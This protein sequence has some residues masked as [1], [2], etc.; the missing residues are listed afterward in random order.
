[1]ADRCRLAVLIA[2]WLCGFAA[3]FAA[4][5]RTS[6]SP[7]Q[8]RLSRRP[9]APAPATPTPTRSTRPTTHPNESKFLIHLAEDQKDIWTSPFHLKPGDA[10]WL[11]PAA[12]IT[13]GLLV[14]DPQSSYAMRLGDLSAWKTASNVGV[15]SAMGMT[16]AAYV[17]GRITHNERMRET[18]V[19]ATEA[20]LNALGVDY[21]DQ[22]RHRASASL[23]IQLSEYFLSRRHFVSLR[24]RGVTWAFASM[25]AHEYPNLW[26]EFGAYGLALG[27]SLA[28]A[29]SEQHF[30]SDVFVGS[31]MGYQIGRQIYK[32]RHNANLD[33]D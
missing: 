20:M 8:P 16:G 2:D 22:G 26:A 31:V 5:I 18:G 10:K 7:A 17:W 12:G 19:L 1:M 11:V 29:A 27:T 9:E 33:D 4:R 28:R 32:Q 13:T 30:L 23:S 15:A 14:T 6:C 21:C 3:A 24:S 25:I